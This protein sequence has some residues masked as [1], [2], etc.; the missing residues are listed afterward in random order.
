M[1][2]GRQCK[3]RKIIQ[4]IA[5]WK[6]TITTKEHKSNRANST[7]EREEM[8][9]FMWMVFILQYRKQFGQLRATVRSQHWQTNILFNHPPDWAGQWKCCFTLDRSWSTCRPELGPAWLYLILEKSL[10]LIPIPTHGLIFQ[11]QRSVWHP[12]DGLQAAP[13]SSRGEI[14]LK[15]KR[16]NFDVYKQ[17][18]SKQELFLLLSAVEI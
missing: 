4:V 9:G 8:C 3:F 14:Q 12:L 18:L 16:L 7:K 1:K 2:R 5:Q 17:C 11:P 10:E 15:I 13:S 6:R